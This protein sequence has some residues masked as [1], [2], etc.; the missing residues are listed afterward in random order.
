MNY[1]NILKVSENAT[2]EEITRAKDRLKF[3][4]PD[5]R[6]PFNEW[7][8]IDEAYKVLSSL[9]LRNS[10]DNWLSATNTK[11]IP[12][13][14]NTI[15]LESKKTDNVKVGKKN[16][17][18]V[19]KF[20]IIKNRSVK[21]IKSL[22]TIE[23]NLIYEY[24]NELYNKIEKLLKSNNNFIALESYK[25][26]YENQ[27]KLLEK[28]F[29]SRININQKNFEKLD[30]RLSLIAFKDHLDKHKLKYAEIIKKINE[31]EK[32]YKYF[33]YSESIVI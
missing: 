3:G 19:K 30:V 4:G 18:P 21:H 17:I 16:S 28:M 20:K 11:K 29:F 1:Y 31:Y 32:N 6:A 15:E 8:M 9:E 27:I 2:I 33:N 14:D 7:A 24:L 13:G 23:L 12:V 10:Y 5:E 22:S 25:L 26:K